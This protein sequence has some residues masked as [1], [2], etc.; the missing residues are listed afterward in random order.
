M[1][2]TTFPC[3]SVT[4]PSISFTEELQEF[5][6]KK[7]KNKKKNNHI[8]INIQNRMTENSRDKILDINFFDYILFTYLFF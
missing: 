7:E 8:Q 4:T 2:W 3:E 6:L 1:E 5:A